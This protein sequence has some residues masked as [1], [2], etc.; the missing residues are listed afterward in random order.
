VLDQPILTPPATVEELMIEPKSF[1]R[2]ARRYVQQNQ[3]EIRHKETYKRKYPMVIFHEY[4]DNLSHLM[5]RMGLI[6][7]G[8]EVV[9]AF[10]TRN[11]VSNG[12]VEY[13]TNGTTWSALTLPSGTVYFNS[14]FVYTSNFIAAGQFLGYNGN[15][16][17]T[18]S[19]VLTLP[20]TTNTS[21]QE[22]QIWYDAT[23]STLKCYIGGV[24]KTITV[25]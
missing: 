18:P 3:T 19:S 7:A 6:S 12:N 10:A 5:N 16:Q 24:L 2:D 8:A 4:V 15:N 9:Y 17:W 13:S 14:W 21:Y 1:A 25:S 22:G 11:L 20:P 23:T